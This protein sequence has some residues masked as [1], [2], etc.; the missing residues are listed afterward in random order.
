MIKLGKKITIGILIIVTIGIGIALGIYLYDMNN[1]NE[2][3]F[4][5]NI[6]NVNVEENELKVT[7]TLEVSN[8]EEK[9]TPNTLIVYTTYYTK[10]KHY[11]NEYQDIDATNVNLTENDLREKYKEW[12]IASFSPNQVNFEKEVEGFC[13]QHFKLK[14]V[15]DH[16]VIYQIDENN[17]ET[18]Y[19]VTE[20]TSEYL[21]QED[22]LKLEEGIIVYGKENLSSVIEDYE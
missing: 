19:E 12:K 10:C 21:T 7:N 6:M 22:V 20:I 1:I 13:N 18:E 5:N 16:I 3:S 9:T 17:N 15:N 14:L 2:E 11:I 8:Q 4:N